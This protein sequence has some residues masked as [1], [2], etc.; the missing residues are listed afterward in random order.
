MTNQTS[1]FE[2]TSRSVGRGLADNWW[3]FLLRGIA[4]IIFGVLSLVWPGVTLV[5]LVL[6]YGAYVL[7]DGVCALFAGIS[8]NVAMGSRW[9][10]VVVGLLGI[11]AGVVTFMSP[12]ITAFVLLFF[13]ACW[14]VATGLFQ[15]IGAIQLRKDI[16]NEWLLA[17]HGVLSLLFGIALFVMPGVGLLALI[18]VIGLYAIING[19]LMI[20][21]AFRVRRYGNRP[22]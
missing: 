5:T 11:A 9:W 8:G 7:V 13:D 19:A 16:D 15:I 10:L 2:A 18:W 22:A 3:L 14:A 21:F 20:G 12:G 6:F 1:Y 4:A 17:I